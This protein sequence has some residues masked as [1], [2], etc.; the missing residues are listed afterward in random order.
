MLYDYNTACWTGAA[1][2]CVL[3]HDVAWAPLLLD[4]AKPSGVRVFG[5]WHPPAISPSP[6]HRWPT[7]SPPVVR[8]RGRYRVQ[9]R[10]IWPASQLEDESHE[11]FVRLIEGK[12]LRWIARQQT[13]VVY[14]Q[15]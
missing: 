15:R 12:K 9:K 6:N 11:V 4:D 14:T 1:V 10:S 8:I 2:V 5:R 7:P 13:Y 3:G